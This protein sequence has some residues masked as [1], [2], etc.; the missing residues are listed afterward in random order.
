MTL[1]GPSVTRLTLPEPPVPD[2]SST[3]CTQ[4][5]SV[6]QEDSVQEL[7]VREVSVQDLDK[8]GNANDKNSLVQELTIREVTVQEQTG[9]DTIKL[10]QGDGPLHYTAPNMKSQYILPFIPCVLIIFRH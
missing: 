1:P 10:N 8:K 4:Q 9:R 3:G 5:I 6:V 7:T 2:F